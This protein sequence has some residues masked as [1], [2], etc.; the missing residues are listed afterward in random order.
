M[1]E[2][3]VPFV[4][5]LYAVLKPLHEANTP[6]LFHLFTDKPDYGEQIHVGARVIVMSYALRQL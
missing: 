6:V 5:R 3:L 1:F 2:T 4:L